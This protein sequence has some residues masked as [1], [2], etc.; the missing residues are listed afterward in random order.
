MF[1]LAALFGRSCKMLFKA[2]QKP[3]ALMIAA[4]HATRMGSRKCFLIAEGAQTQAQTQTQT[5]T[6]TGTRTLLNPR[7]R[8]AERFLA[9]GCVFT[10]QMATFKSPFRLLISLASASPSAGLIFILVHVRVHISGHRCTAGSSHNIAL[11]HISW[12]WMVRQR[13][14]DLGSF[15]VWSWLNWCWQ[16]MKGSGWESATET[17]VRTASPGHSGLK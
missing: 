4:G 1:L 3:L 7:N 6:R 12:A 17:S 15:A 11:A 16:R 9:T 10:Q 13:R 14:A 2:P 5:Q 8:N